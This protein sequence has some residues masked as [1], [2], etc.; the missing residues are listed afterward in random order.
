[1]SGSSDRAS[2]D[3]KDMRTGRRQILPLFFPGEIVG[4]DG[5][6]RKGVTV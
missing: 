6:F 5:E 3:S 1:M 2:F 4:F